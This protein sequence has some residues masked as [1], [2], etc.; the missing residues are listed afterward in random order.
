MES[1]YYIIKIALS[2]F[3]KLP[4]DLTYEERVEVR[5]IYMDNY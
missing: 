4:E 1:N 5:N 2:V 3:D